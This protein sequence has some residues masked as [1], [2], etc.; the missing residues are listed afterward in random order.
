MLRIRNLRGSS[1]G[2]RAFTLIELLVVIVIILLLVGILAPAVMSA[3]RQ[4]Q[5]ARAQTRIAELTQG[6]AGFRSEKNY[7]PGQY[8]LDGLTGSQKLAEELFGPNLD[9]PNIRYASCTLDSDHKKSDLFD[10]NVVSPNYCSMSRPN[11]I[12]DRFG[13]RPMAILYYPAR[14]GG[15]GVDQYV[16]ADNAPYFVNNAQADDSFDGWYKGSF[17]AFI[18][19]TRVG[20]R[21]Y[22]SGTFLLMAAGMDRKYGTEDDAKNWNWW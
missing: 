14:Q 13:G 20:G 16:E 22:N 1:E 11:S 9:E 18:T 12:S 6:I 10:P 7:Y 21:P 4:A 15:T 5:V 19:D 17:G 3:I 8:G 2:R